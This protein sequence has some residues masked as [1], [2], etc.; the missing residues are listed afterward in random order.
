MR[1][2]LL[3]VFLSQHYFK[4]MKPLQKV[5]DTQPTPSMYMFCLQLLL[6]VT[7]PGFL[8]CHF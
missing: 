1:I 4:D 6:P 3:R 5:V 2:F 8:K 7:S